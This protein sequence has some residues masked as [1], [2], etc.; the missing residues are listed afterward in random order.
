MPGPKMAQLDIRVNGRIEGNVTV[1]PERLYFISSQG[2]NTAR[3]EVRL[4]RRPEGGLEILGVDVDNPGFAATVVPVSEDGKEYKIDVVR[5]DPAAG[6]QTAKLTIRTNEP[7][8]AS[9]EVPIIAR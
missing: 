1:R 3:Q 5:A 4:T 7:S 8:Q 9:I 6:A 2:G